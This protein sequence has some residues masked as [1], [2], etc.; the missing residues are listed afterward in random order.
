MFAFNICMGKGAVWLYLNAG[1]LAALPQDLHLPP[2][3]RGLFGQVTAHRAVHSCALLRD[4]LYAKYLSD[5]QI[6]TYHRI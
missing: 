3:L 5:Y 1:L 6:S 4:L 2:L